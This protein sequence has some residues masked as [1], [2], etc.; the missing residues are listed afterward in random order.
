MEAY[1]VYKEAVGGLTW[2]GD[3]MKEFDEMPEKQR[4]AWIAVENHFDKE[5]YDAIEENRKIVR[6]LKKVLELEN[7]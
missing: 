3:K 7:I 2:N 4:N 6:A 1:N 5:E